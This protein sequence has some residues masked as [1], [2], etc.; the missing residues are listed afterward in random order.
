MLKALWAI[1]VVSAVALGICIF[2]T[3]VNSNNVRMQSLKISAIAHQESVDRKQIAILQA[4]LR[5]TRPVAAHS[6]FLER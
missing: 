2:S 6:G 3:V 1:A 4:E 5:A